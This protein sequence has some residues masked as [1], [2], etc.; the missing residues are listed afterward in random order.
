MID[1]SSHEDAEAKA[2][3]EKW[4][5]ENGTAVDSD[6]ED[7][8]GEV[9]DMEDLL[10][11][12]R[13]DVDITD[14]ALDHVVLG[15]CDLEKAMAD[16][17]AMTGIKP[18]GVTSMNG[19]GTKKAQ[20]AFENCAYLEIIGPDPKQASTPLSEKL[21]NFEEGKIAPIHFAVRS[22][23][24]KS[25][26]ESDWSKFDVDKITMV[27]RDQGMPWNWDLYILAGHEEA[28]L[29]PHFVQW[30]DEKHPAAK[31][32]I[33]G[34]LDWVGVRAPSDSSVHK[35]LDGISGVAVE[36]GD[37]LLEVTFTSSKGTHTFSSTEPIGVTFP[38]EGGLKLKEPT[39]K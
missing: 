29:I 23:R 36:S 34:S 33:V 9:L 31:L 37:A 11:K 38:K 10:E 20:V 8:D 39:Y 5:A 27:A 35:L 22:T 26:K 17:E 7:D 32:P 30:S 24:C 4:E 12:F 6:D 19:L 13:R 3:M 21:Q 2:L 15:T 28:G 25:R 1:S 18:I 14:D 16:L